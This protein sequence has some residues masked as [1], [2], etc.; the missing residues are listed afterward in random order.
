MMQCTKVTPDRVHQRDVWHVLHEC[1]KV[2]GRVDRAVKELHE[3]TPKVEK[4]AKRMAA[5]KKPL[6]RNPKT[7][8]VAHA[9]RRAADGVSS[10][11]LALSYCRTQRTY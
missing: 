4:Q 6:G 9:Q 8:V 5:G 1:Q 2:Q 10:N 7:D 3:Q 11:K